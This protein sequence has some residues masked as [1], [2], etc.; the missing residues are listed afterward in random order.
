MEQAQRVRDHG[1]AD[2][3]VV[4][5]EIFADAGQWQGYVLFL[6]SFDNLPFLNN[7]HPCTPSSTAA[8]RGT[9][10]AVKRHTL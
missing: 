5:H 9:L 3:G 1:G 8:N 7:H 10:S 2:Q 6:G 4:G